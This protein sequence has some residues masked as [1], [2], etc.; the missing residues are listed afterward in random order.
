MLFSLDWER[1]WKE[2]WMTGQIFVINIFRCHYSISYV[3]TSFI[4]ITQLLIPYCIYKT[5]QTYTSSV[6]DFL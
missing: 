3:L 1:M 5:I 2:V 6:I 4:I